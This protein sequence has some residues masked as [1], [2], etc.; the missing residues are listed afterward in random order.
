MTIH[1]S[2]QA[3]EFWE[4]IKHRARRLN[5]AI[6]RTAADDTSFRIAAIGNPILLDAFEVACSLG[7]ESALIDR[8]DVVTNSSCGDLP[9]FSAA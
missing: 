4:W 5:L 3:D 2:F 9:H 8:I 1:G 6:S 7:P